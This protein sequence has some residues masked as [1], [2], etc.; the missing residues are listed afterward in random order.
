M[1][2][3]FL[4]VLSA[5]LLAACA[6]NNESSPALV[7]PTWQLVSYGWADTSNPAFP[8]IPA[9]LTFSQDGTLSGN[10]GCNEFSVEYRVLG[11]Q[12][13]FGEMMY[14]PMDCQ[15][16]KLMEQEVVVVGALIGR[17]AYEIDGDTLTIWHESG[18]PTLVFQK[19]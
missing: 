1:K 7:G 19:E 3:V 9:R 15:I 4:L 10:M 14:F 16:E 13:E 18:S 2:K 5:F 6:G 12:L 11:D 8:D 17:L